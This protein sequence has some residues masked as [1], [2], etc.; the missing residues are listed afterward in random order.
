MVARL[1]GDEFVVTAA[2]LGDER[3]ARELGLKLVEAF[4]EP[5]D[6]AQD[7]QCSVGLTIGYVLVPLDGVDPVS[8]LRQADAAMYAGKQGGKGCVRRAVALA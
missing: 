8:L 3:Q 6:L 5:F 7:R 4:R 2:G 1:G